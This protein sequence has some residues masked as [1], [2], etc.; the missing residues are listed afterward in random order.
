MTPRAGIAAIA[1]AVLATAALY[2]PGFGGFWLG[3]DLANLHQMQAW[4]DRGE[5][6][7]RIL[8]QFLEGVPSQGAF[9]RP[10]TM[11]SLAASHAAFGPA[12][13]GWFGIGF[14]VHLANV[15]LVG[16]LVRRLAHA[17]GCE[18]WAGPFLAAL[19]FGLCP[20]IAEGVYWVS[21]RADGWVTLATLAG[22]GAWTSTRK[23]RSW[24]PLALVAALALALGFK[25]SAALV[26]AQVA[27]VA[28]AWPRRTSPAQR[29]A[30]AGAFAL[31]VAFLLLRAHLFGNPWQ[32]YRASAAE[33]T[34][35]AK[36]L[37]AAGS[38]G[39]W[40]AG[41]FRDA[42]AAALAYG[43]LAVS[44]LAVLL[45]HARG[46]QARL[47]FALALAAAGHAAATLANLGMLPPSG[48][49][50]RLAYGPAAWLALAV[51]VAAS[52]PQR[53]PAGLLGRGGLPGLGLA[54]VALAIAAGAIAAGA[55]TRHA[56]LAQ[57]R[58]AALAS[59]VPGWA[60]G[61]P[62]LTMLVVPENDA[63]VVIARNGQ[64]GL[65]LPPVQARAW[66]DRVVPTLPSEL[67]L[68]FGQFADGT[69]APPSSIACWHAR[70]RRIV[71][72]PE[73]PRS[74]RGAWTAAI[75]DSLPR[76]EL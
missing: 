51:G 17:S 8:A 49:G 34:L 32:V 74:E 2:A 48:E 68:R 59:A 72:L 61:H 50:G 35:V 28:L 37:G 6:L 24:R 16:L 64:G 10:L 44:A 40:S 73:P 71:L 5:I 65:V 56:W 57:S 66:L 12:H 45:P 55:V 75:R 76:C 22:L 62:G 27:L 25:E 54:L 42:P 60:A 21:A 9:Y 41:L 11:A 52:R 18:G 29:L 46:A 7:A 31:V 58:F 69:L 47:A 70:E 30:I 67:E 53:S 14:A 13:A 1:L 43:A 4:Q 3:D 63:F 38:I 36:L 19:F 26:P 20:V 33:T 23:D 39:P 15:A